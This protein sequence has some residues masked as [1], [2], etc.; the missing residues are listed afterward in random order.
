[1]H[2]FSREDLGS[3]SSISAKKW[4]D[5]ELNVHPC[6]PQQGHTILPIYPPIFPIF[7]ASTWCWLSQ[8]G[9]FTA[10]LPAIL[11]KKTHYIRYISSYS[12][13]A[14]F[15]GAGGE[16]V[17]PGAGGRVPGSGSEPRIDGGGFP[18]LLLPGT[19]MGGA[20]STRRGWGSTGEARDSHD[21]NA[22]YQGSMPFK[23]P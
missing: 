6:H 19:I 17:S 11:V 13:T 20:R 18:R 7:H 22:W 3:T 15:K 5:A 12:N 8:K 9:Y 23:V 4:R 10:R 1:M 21:C 2:F 16:R 14:L